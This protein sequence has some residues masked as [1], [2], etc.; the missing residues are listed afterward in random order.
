M[1]AGGPIILKGGHVTDAFSQVP[2]HPS[3][4][5]QPTFPVEAFGFG[6]AQYFAFLEALLDGLL[7]YESTNGGTGHAPEPL[8]AA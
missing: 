6:T 4:S 7:E 1:L 2:D 5:S 8:P 3:S